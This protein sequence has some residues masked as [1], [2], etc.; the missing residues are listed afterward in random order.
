MSEREKH[1]TFIRKLAQYEQ[2]GSLHDLEDQ[3]SKAEK[4]EKCVRSAAFLVSLIGLISALGIAY[5]TVVL[6]NVFK[7]ST[8]A[9]IRFSCWRDKGSKTLGTW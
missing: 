7:N 6:E 2:D 9:F 5:S 1:I 8:T 3:I 4:E